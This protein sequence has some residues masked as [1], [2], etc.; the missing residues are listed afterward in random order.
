MPRVHSDSCCVRSTH[1][2]AEANS[3]GTGDGNVGVKAGIQHGLHRCKHHR[4]VVRPTA[5]HH[6][7]K[8]D[9]L[10]RDNG[11]ALWDGAES[12]SLPMLAI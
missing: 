11:I 9:G 7:T 8:C 1:Y 2:H 12:S 10:G 4:E 6:G 3:T 5:R